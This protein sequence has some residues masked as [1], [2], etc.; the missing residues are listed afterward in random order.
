[1][2]KE[3]PNLYDHEER[4]VNLEGNVREIQEDLRERYARIDESNKYLREL[5]QEQIK[6][7]GHILNSVLTGNQEAAKRQ[8]EMKK[9]AAKTRAD[10]WLKAI[11]S[12]GVFYLIVDMIMKLLK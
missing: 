10:L 8:D 9:A 2:S 3:E 7:N 5:S 11:G 12:G 4:I 1:M 6:Q